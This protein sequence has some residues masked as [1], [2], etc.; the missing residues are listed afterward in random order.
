MFCRRRLPIT[1]SPLMMLARLLVSFLFTQFNFLFSNFWR[2]ESAMAKTDEIT[3]SEELR[4]EGLCA[5]WL[6]VISAPIVEYGH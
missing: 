1:V 2:C 4:E 3:S 6:M 5:L